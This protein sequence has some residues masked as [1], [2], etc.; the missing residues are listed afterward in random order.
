[1]DTAVQSRSVPAALTRPSPTVASAL[2]GLV[3]AASAAGTLLPGLLALVFGGV[4]AARRLSG[5]APAPPGPG[6]VFFSCAVGMMLVWLADLAV[7]TTSPA[8]RAPPGLA[9]LGLL[10]SLASVA[11]PPRLSSAADGVALVVATACA[12]VT[13][14]QGAA[15]RAPVAARR[16]QGPPTM[17]PRLAPDA[18]ATG[19][20]DAEVSPTG[21]LPDGAGGPAAAAGQ[22]E[23]GSLVQRFE[24]RI[25]PDGSECVRGRLHVTVPT[26]ARFGAGHVGFCPPLSC[27]PTVRVFTE[28]DEVEA[29]VTAAEVLPW[30]A[31]IECRLDEPAEEAIRVPIDLSAR[32]PA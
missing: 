32:T 18:F 15:A 19:A 9:R 7:R 13:L 2:D 16:S 5:A 12:A 3:P 24:R 8:R 23:P 17:S 27:A 31:R 25:L 11:L 26:G 6:A 20:S 10:V 14:L 30:G 21:F 22:M 29:I 28:Y 4:I 1:M